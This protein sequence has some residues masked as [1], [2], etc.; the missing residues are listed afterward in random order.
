MNTKALFTVENDYDI[1][2]DKSPP[3]QLEA[4]LGAIHLPLRGPPERA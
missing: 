2:L 1:W 4:V 3:T